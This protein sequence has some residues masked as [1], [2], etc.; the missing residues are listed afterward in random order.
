VAD[1]AGLAAFGVEPRLAAGWSIA[2]GAGTFAVP[3]VALLGGFAAVVA[4]AVGRRVRTVVQVPYLS[5]AGM[6]G[7]SPATFRGGLGHPIEA[8][9]GGFY[10]GGEP[11]DGDA[12]AGASRVP[13]GPVGVVGR[14][15]TAV[16]WALVG[17]VM[18]AAVAGALGWGAGP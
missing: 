13:G 7:A 12:V 9:S 16:G 5:G 15:M 2:L 8:H 18:L 6:A 17:L 14:A 11:G 3:A 4:L 1:P 10:W